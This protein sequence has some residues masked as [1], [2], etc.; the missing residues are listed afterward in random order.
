M[1]GIKEIDL[2]VTL[3]GGTLIMFLM[4]VVIVYTVIKYQQRVLKQ[5]QVLQQKEKLF[6][7]SLLEATI[8][9]SEKERTEVSKNL[10]DDVGT[11]L[12]VIKINNSRIQKNVNNI[13]LVNTLIKNNNQLLNDIVDSVRSISNNLI[14]P[15]LKSLGF[16]KAL[17]SLCN[18]I[19]STNQIQIKL[20]YNDGDKRF[21]SD[22]ELNLYRTC[23]EVINNIIKHSGA[24]IILVNSINNTE[25]LTLNFLYN[26]KGINNEE[27]E[28]IIKQN[29][30]LGLKSI[31][32]RLQILKASI[33]YVT[34]SDVESEIIIKLQH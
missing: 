27:V 32:S 28:R 13:V 25:T 33:N 21:N 17:Q 18:I 30:G 15:T 4:V 12:N 26:G 9:A 7:I 34:K 23:N 29:K 8:N 10:H 19:N 31:I 20:N 2:I 3:I 24:T 11:L 5:Q 6:Q 22:V 14:S 16:F 1:E